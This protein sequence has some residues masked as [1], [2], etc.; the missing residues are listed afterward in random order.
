MTIPLSHPLRSQPHQT[1]LSTVLC[2]VCECVCVCVWCC[3]CV[4]VCAWAVVVCVCLCPCLPA[5]E[6]R[7]DDPSDGTHPVVHVALGVGHEQDRL[8]T[9]A[10]TLFLSRHT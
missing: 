5:S 1:L 8:M 2:T 10:S 4:F 6:G 3:V 9:D 7:P